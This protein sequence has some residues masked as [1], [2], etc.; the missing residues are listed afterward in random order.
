MA[1]TAEQFLLR[2]GASTNPEVKDDALSFIQRHYEY[3]ARQLAKAN[4]VTSGYFCMRDANGGVLWEGDLA[5][6][7]SD[8]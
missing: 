1:E 4:G 5:A 8:K 7:I 6:V 3:M 2:I